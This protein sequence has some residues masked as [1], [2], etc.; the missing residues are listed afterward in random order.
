MG[1]NIRVT[2]HY[3]LP[4]FPSN[5]THQKTFLRPPALVTKEQSRTAVICF[6]HPS[7]NP[8]DI[9]KLYFELASIQKIAHK[10]VLSSKPHPLSNII[11][12]FSP[13]TLYYTTPH[14]TTP[15]VVHH[16][17]I[18]AYHRLA[19]SALIM[20]TISSSQ[21]F[22][23]ASMPRTTASTVA[24]KMVATTPADLGMDITQR[25]GDK[26]TNGAMMD[27]KG[28]AFSVSRHTHCAPTSSQHNTLHYCATPHI[29]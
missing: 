2:C 6:R 21:A 3:F 5:K 10:I 1:G 7:T 25:N 15:T 20:A 18:M 23:P 22:T 11:Y 12:K 13:L 4:S 8:A 14:Y 27:L 17:S 24:L 28:I 29:T 16:L 9:G 26:N 19:V